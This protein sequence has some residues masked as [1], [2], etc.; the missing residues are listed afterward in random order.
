LNV[1]CP[2]WKCICNKQANK[3]L[4]WTG[5]PLRSIPPVSFDV[6]RQRFSVLPIQCNKAK[7][8]AFGKGHLGVVW[9]SRH[10]HSSMRQLAKEG[11]PGQALHRLSQA[12]DFEGW[13]A[14]SS[15]QETEK[16][17]ANMALQ[18]TR[19]RLAVFL[20]GRATRG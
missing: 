8:A 18:P 16:L 15:V 1:E 7:S 19:E 4:H 9:F 12:S 14:E 2:C 5:I 10:I 6:S 17:A 20:Q 3:A 11:S 13:R